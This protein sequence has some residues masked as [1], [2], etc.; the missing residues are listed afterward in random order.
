MSSGKSAWIERCLTHRRLP[1][2]LALLAFTLCLPALF[3][4]WRLD[5]YFH[6]AAFLRP[7]ALSGLRGALPEASPAG[8]FRFSDGDRAH[9]RAALELGTF[10]WWTCPEWRAQF[11]RP[12]AAL[13][14]WLD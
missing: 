13:T 11:F 4:G 6:R 7:P 8:L 5:D 3:S 9:V 1:L 12:L 14:H 10:P 2:V